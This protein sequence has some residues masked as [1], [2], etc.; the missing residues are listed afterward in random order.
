LNALGLPELIATSPGE[1]EAM[2][3]K[4][5]TQPAVLAQLKSKLA[6]NR[7]THLLFD[8]ERY[9]RHLESAYAAMADRSRRGEPPASFGVPVV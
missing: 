1:Y 3:V 2:A 9:C 4:L 7:S 6:V 8:T 5:A